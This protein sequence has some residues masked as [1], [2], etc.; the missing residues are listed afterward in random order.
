MSKGND[1]AF[2]NVDLPHYHIDAAHRIRGGLT[3]REY[4]AAKAMQGFL[5]NSFKP[6]N[7]AKTYAQASNTTIAK[8]SVDAADALLAELDKKRGEALRE[9]E[10]EAD[11][12]GV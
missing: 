6:D 7:G 1:N 4:F 2:P 5:A 3:K 8:L 11:Q 9:A 10:R 12:Y